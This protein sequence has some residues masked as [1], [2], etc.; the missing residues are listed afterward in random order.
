MLDRT[1]EDKTKLFG[2]GCAPAGT[3]VE[4]H[5]D[6]C[7]AWWSEPWNIVTTQRKL[8]EPELYTAVLQTKDHIAVIAT[9]GKVV[10]E[11]IDGQ[12]V[13]HIPEHEFDMVSTATAAVWT[14]AHV[15][16]ARTEKSGV[17]EVEV[18]REVLERIISLCPRGHK[19]TI[20]LHSGQCCA[21]PDHA[22]S[23]QLPPEEQE[24]WDNVLGLMSESRNIE[25]SG[26]GRDSEMES[27][28]ELT[29]SYARENL[30]KVSQTLAVCALDGER[31]LLDPRG[32]M[33]R[34]CVFIEQVPRGVCTM[35]SESHPREL[36]LEGLS[37]LTP[38]P[39]L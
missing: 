24:K 10:V 30:D 17:P 36:I 7:P 25:I 3:C 9:I 31:A 38:P 15:T 13:S 21:L 16:L 4:P 35:S 27:V 8:L 12:I 28:Q 14:D 20:Q 29:L 37:K 32:A 26:W 1:P 39:C 6:S 2:Y 33:T 22:H 19:M 18:E 34:M 23:R 11:H 5:Y